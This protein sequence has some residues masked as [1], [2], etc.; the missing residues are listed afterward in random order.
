MKKTTLRALIQASFF[1]FSNGYLKGFS[2]GKIFTGN[3][4]FF[5]TPGLNCYSCPGALA[6]CPIGSL[7][8]ILTTRE[9]TISFYLLG[10]FMI[11]GSLLGRCICGFLCP[12]GF[13]Q[14]LLF[15]IPCIKKI[16]H[17][18]GEKFLRSIRFFILAIFVILLPLFVIDITGIGEP[19]FCKFICPVGTLEGGIP[20]VLANEALR[21]TLGFLYYWKLALLIG[22]ILLSIILFRPF[23][24]YLC[25]LGAIYGIFNKFSLYRFSINPAT[26]TQC[27]LCKK[28]CKLGIDVFKNPNSIDC[29][30]CGD[31]IEG[32]PQ[33]AI[34]KHFLR[35]K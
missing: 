7:Q 15:K 35:F 3:T 20:L 9:F 33:N 14:D 17:L 2:Q 4:K 10:F 16:A 22:I 21:K 19:W 6:S 25:P 1:A 12:F 18:P 27:G 29:I 34:E 28:N 31:C 11:F 30:R 26:C 5:C 23:C 24:R 8:A 13:F 32:C